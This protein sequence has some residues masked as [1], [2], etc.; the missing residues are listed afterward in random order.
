MSYCKRLMDLIDEIKTLKKNNDCSR[1]VE[2]KVWHKKVRRCLK[3][4]FGEN[5]FE[6][7]DFHETL[8]HSLVCTGNESEARE[9][10]LK[11]YQ[12]DLEI[13]KAILSSYIREMMEEDATNTKELAKNDDLPKILN[14]IFVSHSSKDKGYVEL[15]IQLLE[16]VGL[17]DS[18]VLCTS[19]TGLGIPL[20]KNIFDYLRK[21][22]L[23]ANLHV[24]FIHS[25]NYYDSPVS[26]NEMVAAWLAKSKHTSILLPGFEYNEMSGV[27]NSDTIGI[28][29]DGDIIEIKDRLNEFYDIISKDF[30]LNKKSQ[31][32]WEQ[33]RDKFIKD[34]IAIKLYESESIDNEIENKGISD[35]PFSLYI[36]EDLIYYFDHLNDR[37]RQQLLV[38]L[39]DTKFHNK[40]ISFGFNVPTD[41]IQKLKVALINRY[42]VRL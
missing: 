11:I 13:T 2:F 28:K 39:S 37:E 22:F 3:D 36:Y 33:I 29:I 24:I 26:L 23:N 34:M 4:C 42:K 1:S 27:V 38:A 35:N 5:S 12:E 20:S 30:N 19:V 17:D 7:S 8:F 21:E 18:N 10:D 41:H 31:I 9:M 15:L 40:L 32:K 16:S 6:Y 14:R 25:K